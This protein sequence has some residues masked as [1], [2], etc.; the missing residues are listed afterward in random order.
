MDN[1]EEESVESRV[2]T[3]TAFNGNR[4]EQDACARIIIPA[5]PPP[6]FHPSFRVFRLSP[7][8]L[9]F[10]SDPNSIRKSRVEKEGE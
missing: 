8:K 10:G 1:W 9:S 7:L 4:L 2:A 6:F 5:A 3:A